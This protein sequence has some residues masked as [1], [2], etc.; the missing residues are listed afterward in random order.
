MRI[1]IFLIIALLIP[2]VS[3]A[4]ADTLIIS[5]HLT[6]ITKTKMYRTY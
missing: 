2:F 4:N 3:Q 6:K 5:E 1:N